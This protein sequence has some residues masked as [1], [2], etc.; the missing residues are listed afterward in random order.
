MKTFY[1]GFLFIAVTDGKKN[2]LLTK[3]RQ[4]TNLSSIFGSPRKNAKTAYDRVAGHPVYQVTTAWGAA[5]MNF[6][7][8]LDEQPKSFEKSFDQPLMEMGNAMNPVTLYYMDPDDAIKMHSEMKQMSNMKKSDIRITT[9]TLAKAIRQSANFG[10]GLPTGQPVDPIT[11][12]LPTT[13][14]GGSL[15]Y[16]IVPSCRQ[17]FYA[18]RCRGKERV[19]LFDETA[20]FDA[21]KALEGPFS[22]NASNQQRRRD[23][24]NRKVTIKSKYDHMEG[25]SGIPVFYSPA[26]KKKQPLFKTFTGGSREENPLF[27]SYEDLEEAW[28]KMRRKNK[29]APVKPPAVEVFNMMDILTSMDREE[30]QKKPAVNWKKPVGSIKEQM[31]RLKDNFERKHRGPGLDSVTF[32]PQKKA[33]EFKEFISAKGN[34]KARIRPMR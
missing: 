6:E 8:R 33:V 16:K 25:Y 31:D 21:E 1:L 9:T 14:D 28:N 10:N 2:G 3:A 12:K 20:T 26:L 22:I 19:G 18:A 17:L 15:R 32:I 23:K 5:Y 29:N 27:F 34:G 30:S 4:F 13:N 7:Q 11:G 24:L